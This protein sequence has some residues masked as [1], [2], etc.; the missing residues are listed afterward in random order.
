MAI[1]TGGFNVSVMPQ[2]P[3]I[4]PRYVGINLNHFTSGI[5][6][7]IS[8]AGNLENLKAFRA[9]QAE[10]AATRDSRIAGENA[11]GGLAELE[12]AYAKGLQDAKM[13]NALA[14]LKFSTE[15]TAADRS[16][17][18][19]DTTLRG[20]TTDL[21]IG[22]AERQ[23]KNT[24][25]I[26]D[27][28]DM[29]L[30]NR[31]I[32]A[33]YAGA[34]YEDMQGEKRALTT[35]QTAEILAQSAERLAKAKAAGT[36]LGA[37]D[38]KQWASMIKAAEAFGTTPEAILSLYQN[39]TLVDAG[40]GVMKPVSVITA[41]IVNSAGQQ[42]VIPGS[43]FDKAP[44]AYR[45]I[46]IATA[47][48]HNPPAQQA[49]NEEPSTK[50]EKKPSKRKIS[51]N[52]EGNVV[53]DSGAQAEAEQAQ[54]TQQEAQQPAP[55]DES[56]GLA[57]AG[58]AAAG[59]GLLNADKIAKVAKGVKGMAESASGSSLKARAAGRLALANS[60]KIVVRAAGLAS[61]AIPLANEYGPKI[62]ANFVED[63]L[64][65]RILRK[66][67]DIDLIAQGAEISRDK[68]DRRILGIESTEEQEIAEYEGI[69]KRY[70][71]I[72]ESDLLDD[73]E[74]AA[75]LEEV[76]PKLEAAR[77]KIAMQNQ[78]RALA[79]KARAEQ[80]LVIPGF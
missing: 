37:V 74:K 54:A 39:S 7:G 28:E 16:F 15:K 76:T 34:N 70:K 66:N 33:A 65:K 36:K 72:A 52:A 77:E 55:E 23:V 78:I 75:M 1:Q 17:L 24:G 42:G 47:Q 69:A 29:E 9:Q 32:E 31:M 6:Q 80:P 71:M 4:D 5:N 18:P 50:A 60:G 22:A 51:I 35:A 68:N 14:T 67:S 3:D 19:K 27:I 59:Y 11:R 61:I 40:R 43:M 62:A 45:N 46:A 48:A 10:L 21:A 38:E 41:E 58:L 49:G 56:G 13:E 73:E 20:L 30:K 79:E 53:S 63:D 12:L 2:S 8:T 57:T 25:K 44:E 26:A 64:S